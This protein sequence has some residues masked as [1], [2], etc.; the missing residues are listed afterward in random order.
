M[1]SYENYYTHI[2]RRKDPLSIDAALGK[3]VLKGD[4]RKKNM[5]NAY[6]HP[7]LHEIHSILC[8]D[9]LHLV[10]I[11]GH[12]LRTSA[13]LSVRGWA[14]RPAS[15]H[16]ACCTAFL[17]GQQLLGSERLVMNLAG[18]FNQILQ[19]SSGEEIPEIDK[20]A[21]ILIFDIDDTP[22][23]LTATDLLAINNDSLLAA[24]DCERDDVLNSAVCS[25]LFIV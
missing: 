17:E 24:N 11:H 6:A 22:F 23:V 14:D 13:Q 10:T 15:S 19:V 21:V 4:G 16:T 1:E 12:A 2:E 20:F 9:L 8:L 18:G 5:A 3:K 25:S 7:S